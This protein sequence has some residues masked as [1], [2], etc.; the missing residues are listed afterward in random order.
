MIELSRKVF[1]F[2]RQFASNIFFERQVVSIAFIRAEISLFWFFQW[3]LRAERFLSRLKTQ[4]ARKINNAIFSFL[5][6]CEKEMLSLYIRN[7]MEPSSSL[8]NL[9]YTK[10]QGRRYATKFLAEFLKVTKFQKYLFTEIRT[11]LI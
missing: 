3:S 4:T 2:D 11:E 10:T 5:K 7:L 8:R 1:F 6:I 9:W